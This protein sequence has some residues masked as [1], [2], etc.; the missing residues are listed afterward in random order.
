MKTFKLIKLTGLG[1]LG[2]V[3]LFSCQKNFLDKPAQGSLAGS[4]IAT[5]TGVAQDLIGSYAA[6]QRTFGAGGPWDAA[7]DNWIYGTVAGGDAHKGSNSGDQAGIDPI[8]VSTENATNGFFDSYWKTNYEGISRC[9]ATIN[10]A[11]A[12][13]TLDAATKMQT[14]AEA[15]FLRGHFY[16]ELRRFFKNVPYLDEKSV[17]FFAPNVTDIYPQIEADFNFAYTNL[18]EKAPDIGRANKWAA[19]AYLAKTYMYEKK[20]DLA[21]PLYDLIISTGVNAGGVKY[22]LM[23]K[24]SDNFYGNTKNNSESVFIL[25]QVANDGT[26]SINNSNQGD[27][28]NFPYNSPFRCCGFLQPTQEL[29]N[30]YRTDLTGLPLIDT[31]NAN[32]NQVINDQGVLSTDLTF[33]PDK[34]P[35]DPRID[36]TMGRRGIP[37]LDWGLHPG[38]NWIRDQPSAGPYSP[39]KNVYYQSTTGTYSDQHSWAPGTANPVNIIRFADVLLMAAEAEANAPTGSLDKAEFYVNLVRTRAS[40]PAGFV[41]TY[42]D[43]KV[44]TGGFTTTPA[45]NYVVAAYT[46]GYFTAQ[47]QAGALKAI[48]FERK[49]ELAM[50]GHRFFDLVRWGTAKPT[51][52][53]FFAFEGSSTPG[54]YGSANPKAFGTSDVAGAT[55]VAGHEYFPIP[56]NQIDLSRVNGVSVLKQNPGY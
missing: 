54:N 3:V 28:L 10:L 12:V 31:H 4:I 19:A 40:N 39:K 45:A 18:L 15:R 29:A 53:A 22:S 36:W 52:D 55:F 43:V 17:G 26:G 50:E 32:A 21:K 30:S 1:L 33:T 44:P 46:A 5:P 24:F 34:G 51:L 25:Q 2:V 11:N 13:A 37:Y 23:P 20:Y 6:L 27:M 16:F 14:L 48:Y 7:P 9:N 8:A 42:K 47:G 38:N 41:Y 35:L 49:L 56:Q